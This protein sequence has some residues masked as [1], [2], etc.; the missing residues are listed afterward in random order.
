MRTFEICYCLDGSAVK[1]CA[2]EAQWGDGLLRFYSNAQKK[3]IVAVFFNAVW[4]RDIT[5]ETKLKAV[6]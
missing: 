1:V 6:A 5:D 3:E 2:E 4:F